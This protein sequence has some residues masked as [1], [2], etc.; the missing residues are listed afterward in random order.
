MTA[1]AFLCDETHKRMPGD[2]A[3]GIG[4]TFT[5]QAVTVNGRVSPDIGARFVLPVSENAA[6]EVLRGAAAGG[7]GP[8][9]SMSP[10]FIGQEYVIRPDDEGRF[11]VKI[12][13]K[14]GEE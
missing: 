9:F 4:Y 10:G 3:C 12:R 5:P 8:I 14:A 11:T 2:G 1:T 6:V 7:P 13:P